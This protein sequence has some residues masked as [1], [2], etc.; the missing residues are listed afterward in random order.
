MKKIIRFTLVTLV[1]LLSLSLFGCAAIERLFLGGDDYQFSDIVLTQ[2]DVNEFRIE[3][4]ANVGR[5]NVQ[6]YFTEGFRRSESVKPKEVEKQT[7]DAKNARFS[8][9][10]SFN[11]GEDYYLWLVNDDKEAKTSVTIPSMFPTI[12]VSE[13][14]AGTFNFNYTYGTSWGSFCDPT[15]K[16]V[17]KSTK[18][19]FDESAVLVAEG[20]DITEEHC[21]LGT[22]GLD[23]YF[24]SVSTAKEGQMKIISRPVQIY[25]Y[26]KDEIDGISANLTSDLFLEVKVN[27]NESSEITDIIRDELGLLIKSD[28]ADEIYLSDAT[29]SDGVATMR[30]DLRNLIYDGLWYDVM[31]TLRGAV[32]MDVPKVFNG[33]QVDGLST[34]KKDGIVYHITSWGPEGAPESAAMIKVYFEEDTTRFADEICKSY[35]VSFTTDP[36]PTLK[37]TIKLKDSVSKAPVL[38]ITAGDKNKLTSCEGVVNADGTISYSLAVGEAMTVAGNWY[39]LR[40]FIDNTAYE[41]LKDSCIGYADFAAKYNDDNNA[42]VYEFKEWNGFLKLNY[43][44]VSAGE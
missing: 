41:M 12:S 40:F 1:I 6:V 30:V 32:V 35:L 15:G 29:Y 37:V 3:F 31:L 33:A 4:T 9:T 2:T 21:A 5:E 18:P 16:A 14:G 36:V 8:F 25:D 38:A 20:I 39:D 17:F 24:Y 34:V 28:I 22:N 13:D 44:S 26:L 19:V 10:G 7:I 23:S 43:T 42:R 11:L 27:I